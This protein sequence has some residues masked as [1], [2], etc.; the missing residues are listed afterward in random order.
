MDDIRRQQQR[1]IDR[2]ILFYVREAQ[3]VAP[4]TADALTSFVRDTRRRRVT[5]RQIEDR[6]HYLVQLGDL[7]RKRE[8]AGGEVIRYEITAQGMDRL[9]GNIPPA[10]WQ[11][12]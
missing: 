12:G 9:D 6:L 1:E 11:P 10:N 3:K 7:D 4:V 8:W 5:E 2:D